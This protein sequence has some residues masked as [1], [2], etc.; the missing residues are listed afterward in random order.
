MM[1]LR[2]AV[3][4][5]LATPVR[6]LI[7]GLLV[8]FGTTLV[9]VGGALL[10]TLDRSMAQSVVGSVSGH[11]Q[12]WSDQARDK[13]DLF[14]APTGTPDLG[15][16]ENFHALKD[17]L[18]TVP[19]VQAVIPMGTDF[20]TVFSGNLLDVKIGE[21]RQALDKGDAAREAVVSE[22]LRSMIGLLKNAGQNLK[23]FAR[24]SQLADDAIVRPEDVDRALSTE[25]WAT[26]DEHRD[27]GLDFL[28]NRIAPLA[29][30]ES[31]LFLRYIGTDPQAFAKS[32]DTFEI[33][34]G[35][36]IPPGQRGFLFAKQ[37]Y[38]RQVKHPVARRF[39]HLCD[40]AER[41]E[42]ISTTPEA[43]TE[44]EQLARL[45]KEIVLQLDGPARAE[46]TTALQAL[47]KS[48]QADIS[49]LVAEFLKVD[50][51]TLVPRRD[52]FYET[53]A[54]HLVLYKVRVGDTLTIR[55]VTRSGYMTAVNV[56]VYGTYRFKGLEKSMLAGVYNLMD[57]MTFR[58]LYGYMTE[59]RRRELAEMQKASGARQIDRAKA[60]DEL[61]GGDVG[62]PLAAPPKEQVAVAE[63]PPAPAPETQVAEAPPPAPA[64]PAGFDEFAGV[65]MKDGGRRYDQDLL[66]RVYSPDEIETGVVTQVALR[67]DSIDRI[68]EAKAT[69]EA[70]SKEK[71]LGL[72]V[73][74][75]REV[76]G[77]VGKF[78]GVIWIVLVTAIVIIF[79]VA[80]VIINN[81]MVMATLDRT[82]EIGAMRA[83]GAQKRTILGL[84]VLESVVLGFGF[85]LVGVALGSTI[86]LVLGHVGIPAFTDELYFLFAGPRLLPTLAPEHFLV[87]FA[88]V[89]VVT[90]ASVFYPA[91]LAMAVQPVEAMGKED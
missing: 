53:I 86:I 56:K 20:A 44:A 9:V 16:I 37:M 58:D 85:G 63:A 59:D 55:S 46:V 74:D 28:E 39:D 48:Q 38:E 64:P 66:N 79:L 62:A 29:M 83:M 22:H 68:P 5:V 87:A 12:V 82:R 10:S 42:T 31:M 19:G 14:N 73:A 70:L 11:L 60:E 84:L 47:L 51:A 78:I 77:L 32:F 41:G 61:F 21:L 49:A 1:L 72:R 71:N 80:L 81:S 23:G 3:R 65:D 36:M 24:V 17:E 18:Q 15:R 30:D 4:N 67:L 88:V 90:V 43:K 57:L 33:V 40:R 35:Q 69:I 75:W 89:F 34:D 76:S 91:R 25:F 8:V 52:F 50:D 13:V 7:I 54:P 6:T 2:M 27:E 26:L 45:G